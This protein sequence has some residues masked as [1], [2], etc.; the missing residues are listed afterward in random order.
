VANENPKSPNINNFTYASRNG[1]FGMNR[2]N[3][4]QI[5]AFANNT[6]LGTVTDTIITNTNS[7]KFV[8]GNQFSSGANNNSDRLFKFTSFGDGLTDA[9]AS[10]LYNIVQTFQTALSRQV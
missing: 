7:N 9:Q 8:I 1:F 2:I 3:N 5:N 10:N 4:T 6:K